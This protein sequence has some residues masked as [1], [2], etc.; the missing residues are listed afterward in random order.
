M[1]SP[2]PALLVEVD[3]QADTG[4]VTE[5]YPI[6]A[7]AVVAAT[8]AEE[9]D[10]ADVP[11]VPDAVWSRPQYRWPRR[12]HEWCVWYWRSRGC[13]HGD[14]CMHAHSFEEYCGPCPSDPWTQ[15]QE[16]WDAK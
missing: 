8:A 4:D 3:A 1:P 13:H 16:Y 2:S 10:V 9:A 7:D 14:N 6:A 11:D 15:V 5:S 12:K